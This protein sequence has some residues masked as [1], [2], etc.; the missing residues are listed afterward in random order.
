MNFFY[1]FTV[2]VNKRGGSS[3]TIDDPCA[4]ICVRNKF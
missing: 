2:S 4:Q 1:A 3:N